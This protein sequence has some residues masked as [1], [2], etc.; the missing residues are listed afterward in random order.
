MV[1]R[2]K[3]VQGIGAGTV[4]AA[5]V[6]QAVV[7]PAHAATTESESSGTIGGTIISQ[8]PGK[9][10]PARVCIVSEEGHYN[11]APVAYDFDPDV[12]IGTPFTAKLYIKGALVDSGG[13]TVEDDPS[14]AYAFIRFKGLASGAK[15]GD[16]VSWTFSIDGYSD[17]SGDSRLNDCT[18]CVS[19]V[20]QNPDTETCEPDPIYSE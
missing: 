14:G 6:V 18:G 9:N 8:G 3:V 5:P 17:K 13:G 12:P 16:A 19:D 2:R 4:W 15:P 7:L 10:R 11:V 20:N 1:D